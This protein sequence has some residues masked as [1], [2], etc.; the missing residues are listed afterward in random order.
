MNGV[1][2]RGV[3]SNLLRCATSAAEHLVRYPIQHTSYF[4]SCELLSSLSRPTYSF[5]R[6]RKPLKLQ[7]NLSV[8]PVRSCHYPFLYQLASWFVVKSTPL[9]TFHQ[10]T[11]PL[12]ASKLTFFPQH[13]L[14]CY[15][16][17]CSQ[18]RLPL[19]SKQACLD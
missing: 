6:T 16:T 4:S 11:F 17:R 8:Q 12:R 5:N 18:I 13:L 9:V 10:L 1:F 14:H 2:L 7:Q 15:L 19:G 3:S